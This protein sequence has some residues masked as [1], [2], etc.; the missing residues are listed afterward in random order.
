MKGFVITVATFAALAT[1]ALSAQAQT[2]TEVYHPDSL[3]I[4]VETTE[5][6]VQA[7]ECIQRGDRS[8]YFPTSRQKELS[9]NALEL[10]E[11][12][13]LNGL[14]VSSLFNTIEVSGGGNAIF[15]INGR[16]VELKDIL[17]LTPDEVIRVEHNSNPG[18]RFKD[19]TVTINFKLK[20]N[21]RGGGF[22]TDLME[23][24]NTV[25]GMNSASGKYNYKNSE[26]GVYYNML[27]AS[28]KE[29]YNEN[30]EQYH[31]NDG[32]S[33][34]Q[35]ENG[36]PGCMRYHHHWLT[37]NY[38]CLKPEKEMWNIA[39][40]GQL[41]ST[42]KQDLN[43]RLYNSEL[44][45][46]ELFLKDYS[47]D[48]STTSA[49]DLYYQR[50]LPRE[51]LFIFDLIGSYTD[52]NNRLNYQISDSEAS[53]Y[54]ITNNVDG[55]K[56]AVIAEALY[57][58][59]L[60][61]SKWSL[62]LKHT[63][64][65]ATNRYSGS[66]KTDNRLRN[67]DSY[68]YAEWNRKTEKWM[69]AVSLGGSYLS[70]SQ[71]ENGYHRFSFRPML[72]AGFT[73][74]DHF[75]LRYR[76]S[77]ESIAPTLSELSQVKQRLDNYQMRCGNPSLNPST[78][79]KSQLTLDYHQKTWSTCLNLRHQYRNHAIMEQTRQEGSYFIREFANQ[80]SWQ[81][82]NA[83]YEVR[84]R[85]LQGMI[86]FR[87]ALGMDYFD[88]RAADYHHTHCNLYAIINAEAAYK[89]VALSFNLRTHRPTL[90]GETLTFGED[91]HDIA[92]T[93]FKKRFSLSLAMNNPFMD[94][95]RFGSENRNSQ[96][97][98]TS[99]RYINETSRML[100]VKMTYGLDFGR[101][102]KNAV[103]RIKNEDTDTGIVSGSK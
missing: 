100:L 29:F 86:S 66:E 1:Q 42:P 93:Y 2:M 97:N 38:N 12:M 53:L 15:C 46:D 79:Y 96:A 10:L 64:G 8:L 24:V 87:G 18:A 20:R 60:G 23:A 71:R 80:K 4:D 50:T 88:S 72:R 103:Q 74:T 51:Q 22:M 58:K 59:T 49:I 62:G 34:L 45:A 78:E 61:A 101:K 77:V 91:L 52:T 83:E 33:V 39:F 98:H 56:Y 47:S 26:W 41:H 7:S 94:N 82:W 68:L 76:G 28:F 70:S 11:K 55:K 19:A 63:S 14:Q 95:Y 89:C 27:H 99:H 16:P 90:Y 30:E 67:T 43:S 17:A 44:S 57:E 65:Y 25:Y 13:Q 35:Q 69:Y 92:V 6:V 3:L 48:R 37:L 36:D 31:Y 40:R 75:T 85:L 54:A 73:P 5:V 102:R 9:S 21:E 81:K 32:H 84:L